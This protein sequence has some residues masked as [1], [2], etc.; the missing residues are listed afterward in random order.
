ML[1]DKKALERLQRVFKDR[2]VLHNQPHWPATFL[3]HWP[4]Q[5]TAKRSRTELALR[6]LLQLVYVET[7]HGTY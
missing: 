3:E 1:V 4:D 2:G 7:A 5:G 6:H